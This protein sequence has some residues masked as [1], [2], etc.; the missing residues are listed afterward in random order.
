M[1]KRVAAMVSHGI[2]FGQEG[3]EGVKGDGQDCRDIGHIFG[4]NFILF[5]CS[6][7]KRK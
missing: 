7:R 1:G 2:L 5:A 3:N 4:T 6:I